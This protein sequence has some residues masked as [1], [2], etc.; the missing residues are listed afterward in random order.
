[1]KAMINRNRVSN[2]ATYYV[3]IGLIDEN[4]KY[5]ETYREDVVLRDLPRDAVNILRQG[6]DV[7][8]HV[9]PKS[10]IVVFLKSR[11]ILDQY[12]AEMKSGPEYFEGLLTALS[13]YDNPPVWG[14]YNLGDVYRRGCPISEQEK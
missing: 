1:M 4:G 3:V 10:E 8:L 5:N 7:S 13:K 6:H 14:T 12:L 11:N 9:V 2:N